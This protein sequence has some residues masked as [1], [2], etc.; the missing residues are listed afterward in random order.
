MLCSKNPCIFD[1]VFCAQ[2]C[3][4]MV[5]I[6]ITILCGK[7]NKIIH[8]MRVLNY[9]SLTMQYRSMTRG[10]SHDRI[11]FITN[12]LYQ[13]LV[14]CKQKLAFHCCVIYAHNYVGTSGHIVVVMLAIAPPMNMIYSILYSSAH[15]WRSCAWP[16]TVPWLLPAW[17]LI[18]IFIGHFTWNQMEVNLENCRFTAT[19][20]SFFFKTGCIYFAFHEIRLK[21][22]IF[23]VL[24]WCLPIWKNISS[25]HNKC[26]WIISIDVRFYSA[27]L[28]KCKHL[29]MRKFQVQTK[30]D[31]VVRN[32]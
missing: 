32:A 30:W 1:T 4:C 3:F 25:T 17:R 8:I 24:T 2:Y 31:C 21:N 6:D 16:I 29:S 27:A 28:I 14:L 12:H 11:T 15:Q 7:C 10:T 26:K 18:I 19:T 13:K 20:V 5:F 23:I 9:G 22:T